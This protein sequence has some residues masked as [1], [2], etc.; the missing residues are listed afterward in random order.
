MLTVGIIP[1]SGAVER[2][3][4]DTLCATVAHRDRIVAVAKLAS[5]TR[6]IIPAAPGRGAYR[7][8]DELQIAAHLSGAHLVY[9]SL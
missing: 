1:S 2:K 9:C 6:H 8:I 3:H 5:S 4:T 7:C